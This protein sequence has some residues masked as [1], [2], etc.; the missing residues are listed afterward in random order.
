MS[1]LGYNFHISANKG[2]NVELT[3]K[4]V[5]V[6]LLVQTDC[7]VPHHRQYERPH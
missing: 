2:V 5:R 7:L 3:S 4:D 1:T 6:Y